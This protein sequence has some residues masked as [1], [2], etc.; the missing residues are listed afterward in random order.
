MVAGSVMSQQGLKPACCFSVWSLHV[1][2]QSKDMH[3]D[4]LTGVSVSVSGCLC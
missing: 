4:R 1:L 3:R 2:P